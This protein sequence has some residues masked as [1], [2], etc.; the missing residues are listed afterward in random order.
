[1][2]LSTK[3][4]IELQRRVLASENFA[5]DDRSLSAYW[6]IP[7]ACDFEHDAELRDSVPVCDGARKA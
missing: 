5:S 1:M 6:T 3:R 7:M 2:S 4:R